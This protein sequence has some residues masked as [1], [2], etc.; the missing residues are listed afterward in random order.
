MGDDGALYERLQSLSASEAAKSE[1]NL[2]HVLETLWET[3]RTGLS[4]SQKPFFQS[5]LGL[6]SLE[7][8][9][10]VLASLRSLIRKSVRDDL[11]A[12]DIQNLLPPELLVEIKS[13]LVMLLQKYQSQ[14]KE[15][16]SKEPV[17]PVVKLN[18][19]A[20][21][22]TIPAS[23]FSSEIWPRQDDAVC[24]STSVND[25][26]SLPGIASTSLQRNDGPV[27]NLAVLPRLKSM[28]WTMEKRNSAP[29][30]RVAVISL[31]LQDY[32][33]TPGGETEVRFQISRDTL[34]AMLRSMTCISD[35]LSNSVRNLNV[36]F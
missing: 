28:T 19:I 32:T 3:R 20:A 34:E 17:F 21:L 12:D 7:D 4:P 6:P 15:D 26:L 31:K 25:D 33:K 29:A 22:T 14:W 36:L 18:T 2:G 27:D 11:G 8:L 16:A 10:L 23:E 35:K 24:A 1:V 30:S 13:T 5:L 9:D